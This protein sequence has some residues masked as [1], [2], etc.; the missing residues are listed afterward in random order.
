MLCYKSWLFL[1]KGSDHTNKY[2]Q[3]KRTH[4]L[5]IHCSNVAHVCV[6]HG[7]HDCCCLCRKIHWKCTYLCEPGWQIPHHL[8]RDGCVKFSCGSCLCNVIL[9]VIPCMWTLLASTHLDLHLFDFWMKSFNLKTYLSSHT[10][11]TLQ[12]WSKEVRHTYLTVP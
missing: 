1:Y 7:Y 10:H 5:W 12:H 8:C 4:G 6:I 9:A 2:L 11:S 3:F